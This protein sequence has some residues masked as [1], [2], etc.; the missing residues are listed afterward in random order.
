ME[1]YSLAISS[2]DISATHLQILEI[3]LCL[4]DKLPA[5]Y[6]LSH[7]LELLLPLLDQDAVAELSLSL[8]TLSYTLLSLPDYLFFP[9]TLYF[10][11]QANERGLLFYIILFLV[12][13]YM[14][15][16]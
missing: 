10:H 4:Q 13:Y 5:F 11:L 6:L 3:A 15:L 8:L 9:D 16:V 14:D 12:L 1:S 2:L 7:L